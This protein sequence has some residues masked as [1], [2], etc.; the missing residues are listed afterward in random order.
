MGGEGVCGESLDQE[1]MKVCEDGGGKG[2]GAEAIVMGWRQFSSTNLYNFPT[3]VVF[4]MNNRQ[5]WSPR[6][7]L[8]MKKWGGDLDGAEWCFEGVV[9]PYGAIEIAITITL[10]AIVLYVRIIRI[11]YQ[12]M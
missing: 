10:P 8:M 3:L 12:N 4:G 1:R 5:Q 9:L 6:Q 11:R 2:F 7:T